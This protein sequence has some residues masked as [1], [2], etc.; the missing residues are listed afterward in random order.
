METAKGLRPDTFYHGTSI[1]AALEI[2]EYGFDVSRAGTNAGSLLGPGV[3]CTTT[4][5]KAMDYAKG[6]PASGIIFELRADLGR[7]KTLAAGDALMKT[8][9]RLRLGVGAKGRESPKSWRKTA[10]RIPPA[11]PLPAPYQ[12]TRASSGGW[13]CWCAMMAGWP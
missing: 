13:E 11:S 3:Y 1:E 8:W 12:E 4:L 6:N 5:E 7:C 10:S 2:Q 9:Q